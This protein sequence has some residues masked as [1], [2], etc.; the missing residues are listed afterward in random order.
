MAVMDRK[1]RT[2]IIRRFASGL[3]YPQLFLL[4][5]ILFLVDLFF[6]DPIPFIDEAMLGLLAVLLGTWKDRKKAEPETP[7]KDLKD[8]EDVTVKDV[9]PKQ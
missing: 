8:A 4:L 9:T 7:P 3:K 2:D 6:P 5:L 1:E